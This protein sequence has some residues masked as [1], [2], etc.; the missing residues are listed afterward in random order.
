MTGITVTVTTRISWW[1]YPYLNAVSLFAWAVGM[2]PD[3]DKVI[4]TAMRGVKVKVR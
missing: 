4:A 2:T 3:A 1:V